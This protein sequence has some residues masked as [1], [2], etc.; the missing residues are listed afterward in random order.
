[1]PRAAHDSTK[2]RRGASAEAEIVDTLAPGDVFAVL[3]YSGGWAWGY[4]QTTHC[5]GYVPA[6]ALGESG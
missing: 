1:M 3:E 6:D 4:A 5:V 2:L